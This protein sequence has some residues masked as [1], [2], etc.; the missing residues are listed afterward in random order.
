[1]FI[2]LLV[3][4]LMVVGHVAH[5]S[6]RKEQ[7]RPQ[8]HFSPPYGWMNDPNGMVYDPKAGEYHLYYQYNPNSTVNGAPHWG[9][10][11]SRDLIH[12]QDLPIALYPNEEGTAFSGSVIIDEHN[13]TGLRQSDDKNVLVAMFTRDVRD[14][15]QSQYGIESQHIWYSNDLGRTYERYEGNPVLI[16]D[17]KI[18]DIRDPKVR[19]HGNGYIAPLAAGDEI[20]FYKSNDMKNWQ[21]TSSFGANPPH[22]SHGIA[23]E[24][25][26]ECP[27]L[28][29]FEIDGKKLWVLFVSINP[30][31]PIVGSAT[32]YFIGNFDGTTFTN[33]NPP[34]KIMWLDMGPDNYA[35]VTFETT[36]KPDPVFIGWAS[37]WDYGRE[38]PTTTWRGQMTMPRTLHLV[39]VNGGE[40]RLRSF[41]IQEINSLRYSTIFGIGPQPNT[42]TDS[43]SGL[44]NLHAINV[45][46]DV[47]QWHAEMELIFDNS[48]NITLSNERGE[49]MVMLMDHNGKI[50]IDR[51]KSGHTIS[52]TFRKKIIGQ[53]VVKDKKVAIDIY[54]DSSLT[55]IFFDKG[56]TSFTVQSFP[57]SMFNRFHVAVGP[58]QGKI[59]D[60]RI[61]KLRSIWN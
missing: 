24:G 23:G 35:G 27:D 42:A 16:E 22:G 10:T 50:T 37:N 13:V 52:P 15:P 58:G 46:T 56:L 26:W 34:N 17:P 45:A 36:P 54:H 60:A 6:D 19:R 40:Y 9:H 61:Y 41:P 49:S 4:T 39:K 14:E 5:A 1:M 48:L 20:R 44:Q 33:L 31:G 8:Y 30:G 47:E 28:I 29:P 7:Y 11:V 43:P 18:K 53:R 21:L 57:T 51:S 38:T 2:F 59:I 55:E 3:R 25:I 32:Q 12:W